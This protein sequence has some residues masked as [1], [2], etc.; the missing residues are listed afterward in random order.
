MHSRSRPHSVLPLVNACLLL[1]AS[2][3]GC[4]TADPLEAIRQQQAAGQFEATIE[5]LRDLMTER[6]DDPEVQYLYGL[7]LARTGQPSL[8]DWSLSEAMRD[9]KWLLPAGHQL[10]YDALA[11]GNHNRAIEVAGT[12]LEAHPDN[13]DILLLRA[14]AYAYSRLHHEAALADVDRI[15]ELDPDNAA[16]MEPRI[17]SLLGLERI[18][19][20]SEAIEEL[21]RQ[22]EKQQLG[23]NSEGWH[24]ATRAI[25]ALDN[26]QEALARERWDD[27]LERFPGHSNVVNNALQF[28]D[29]RAEYDRSLEILRAAQ[30]AEPESR[31]YRTGL[32]GR[33]RL[34]GQT[35]ESEEL[36]KQATESEQPHIATLAWFDLAKHYQELGDHQLASEAQER[37][38]TLARESDLP[39]SQLLLEYADALLLAGRFDEALLIADEMTLEAHQAMIRA[40]VAQQQGRHGDALEHF[41]AAFRLWPNNPYARYYAALASEQV[42]DFDS[43]IES[44]R[45]S[46]RIAAGA[47]DARTR[48]AQLHLAEGRPSEALM[49][50][51]L[52]SEQ[53]PLD[54]PGELLSL[55]LWGR[56]GNMPALLSGLER[57]RQGS[58]LSLGLALESAAEG[59]RERAGLEAAAALLLQARVDLEAPSNAAALRALVRLQFQTPTAD[60]GT[61]TKSHVDAALEKHPQ[62]ADFHEI[63]GLWL[64][65]SG[66][67]ESAG[68]A[69]RAAI[70]IDGQNPGALAGLGRLTPD[71]QEAVDLLERAAAAS[72]DDPEPGW[73]AA[74]RLLA[75]GRVA[76]AEERLEELLSRHP[77]HS[78]AASA[79]ARM[80]LERGDSSE[81]SLELAQRAVR[82]GMD[83][84]TLGLLSRVHQ[85]REEPE[86][87][88]A[89]ER[90][91]GSLEARAS[92]TP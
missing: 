18:E 90:R 66:A 9:P 74:H 47:T 55:K 59:I 7:A 4:N 1:L 92:V 82:F 40:R 67:Q 26:E 49:L 63:L 30:Q 35:Q 24:C 69:Y 15:F 88:Q 45:Y 58:P 56:V 32:A 21:G 27:C 37:A 14:N 91:A 61:E 78:D 16:A 43:A 48:L 33:L 29:S 38:L 57:F 42:G 80:R 5:P 68:A 77:Y 73:E 2:S 70:A 75:T 51:R 76:D 25:F 13:V 84:E 86:L 28:F 20:A 60:P 10:L 31:S 50:L 71:P 8:A 89:A 44:Y 19:E 34:S 12:I 41:D 22:I 64:E 62:V 65:L 85:L 6:R 23:S 83:I 53:A 36:L 87:A 52:K 72:P 39:H 54:L 11:T 81:R 79:L 3:V 46:I 17:L